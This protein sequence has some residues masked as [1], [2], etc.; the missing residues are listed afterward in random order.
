MQATKV[1]FRKFPESKGGDMIALFPAIAATVGKPWQCLSYQHTGQHGGA[2][3]AIVR[4]TVLATRKESRSLW[5][6]LRRI[7]YRL[8]EVYKFTP[9]DESER[10]KQL[11]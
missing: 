3:V 10:R 7:G 6:E 2:D 5:K 11:Q 1:I 9:A 8:K 4:E